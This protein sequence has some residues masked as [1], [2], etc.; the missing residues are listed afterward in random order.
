MTYNC[1]SKNDSPSLRCCCPPREP[2]VALPAPAT[3]STPLPD[4]SPSTCQLDSSLHG[5][6]QETYIEPTSCQMPCY[7]FRSFTPCSPCQ[8]TYASSLGFGSSSYHPLGYG[9][10][11]FF[12]GSCGFSGFRSLNYE[13]PVFPPLTCTSTLCYPIYMLFNSNQPS[14]CVPTCGPHLSEISC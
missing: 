13:V 5:G 8:E 6:C 12:P 7:Y 9:S 11:S 3:W 1:C 14:F 2:A 10:R 4:D